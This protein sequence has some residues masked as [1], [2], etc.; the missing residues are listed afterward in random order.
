MDNLVSFLYKHGI[1][2]LSVVAGSVAVLVGT[3]VIP[4]NHTKYWLAALAVLNYLKDQ[5]APVPLASS[6]QQEKS[7]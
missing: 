6:T 2:V 3:G 5:F 4:E 1:K 7:K